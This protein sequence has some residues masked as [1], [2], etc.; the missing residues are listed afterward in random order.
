MARFLFTTHPAPGH[1]NPL[2]SI[3]DGLR[4]RGH[5]VLFATYAA[6]RVEASVRAAGFELSPLRMEPGSALLLTL[7][8]L[9]GALE[10]GV[11]AAGMFSGLV[12]Y[13][14]QCARL[15]EARGV[16]VVVSDMGF[17][18]SMLAAELAQIP[19]ALVWTAGLSLPGPGIPPFGSGLPIGT[20]PAEWPSWLRWLERRG[21]GRVEAALA[22]ARR[23]LGLPPGPGGAL[24]EVPT[25]WCNLTLTAEAI[26]AERT[27]PPPST[28][29][30]GPCLPSPE[31]ELPAALSRALGE[32]A[33]EVLYVS[34][35]TVFN[36]HPAVFR[37][38]LGALAGPER[39][40]LVSAGASYRAL[41]RAAP[42]PGVHL[43]R[44]VP[45]RALLPRVDLVISHGGNN[46]VNESLAAGKPLLILPVGGEQGD[47][48]ARVVHL[49]VGLRADRLAA[50]P[51]EIAAKARRLL[52]EPSFGER[53]RAL[54]ARLG[55]TD[56]VG[57][58]SRLLERL[59][60]AREPLRRPPGYP[61]TIERGMP[62][63]WEFAGGLSPRE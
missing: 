14:R 29:F 41:R 43:F 13:A 51:A 1:L 45:Q 2:L 58:S 48:A 22:R 27:A 23:R 16:D 63:P 24:R 21:Q 19:F 3:A 47:N 8:A 60:V 6:G 7:P 33:R 46:T 44:S 52:E 39:T 15:I 57:S 28:F 56:G 55:R 42:G 26:E 53:A 20:P 49:G 5:E 12:G 10:L 4:A 18:G 62:M 40:L 61:L 30:V 25:R 50:G 31:P 9:R 38:I 36:R 54:G 34:M 35:G 17:H 59:A 11:A 32:P 37:R